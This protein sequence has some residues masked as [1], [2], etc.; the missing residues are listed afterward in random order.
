MTRRVGA[1]F[2]LSGVTALVGEVVWA[3][4]LGL[5]LGNSVWAASAVVTAWMGGMAL[6]AWLGGRVASRVRAHLRWYGLAEAGIGAFFALSEPLQRLLLGLGAR[7]LGEDLGVDPA[8]GIAVRLALAVAVLAV[9]TVL[10][11]LTLPLLVERLHGLGLT[12]RVGHLYGLNTLGGAAGVFLAAYLLL[13]WLGERGSLA[14][15]ALTCAAVA[16]SAVALEGWVPRGVP[17]TPAFSSARLRGYL[18]LVA[19]MGAGALA[20]ELLWVRVLVLHLGSSVYAF[21]AVLAVYLVGLALGS[22]AV[23]RLGSRLGSPG[24]A[25][26]V[27]QLGIAGL[28]VI[29]LPL[30]GGFG[31]ALA[32]PAT[33]IRIP[34]GFASVQAL[35]VAVVSLY[36]LPVAVLFG[37]CFPLAVAADP[38]ARSDGGHAGAIAAANTLGA[39]LGALGAPFLLV[40]ALGVQRSLLVVAAL[41][42]GVGLALRPPAR[43]ARVAAAAVVLAGGGLWV[44]LPRDWVLRQA[45]VVEDASSELLS[46]SESVS[47]TVAVKRY[48]AGPAPWTSLELNGMNVAGTSRSLLAVQQLQGNLPLLQLAQPRRVLHVGFGSGG[49]CWAVSRHPVTAIDVVE[50]APEVLESAARW[51]GDINRGV[52]SDPRVRVVIND[53]RNFLLATDHRYDAILSDSIHPR[54]AGNSTLYTLEYFQLCRSR[55]EPGGVVSMWLPLYSL[56]TESYLRILSAFHRVFPRTAVWYDISTVNENTVVTGSAAPGPL[57]VDWP[58]MAEPAVAASLAAA[59]VGS[60]DDLAA[61]LLLGPAEVARLVAGTPALIDDLPYVEYVSGRVLDRRRTWLANLDLLARAA[62][63]GPS[64]FSGGS[65]DW[66]AAVERRDDALR[67]TLALLARGEPD[68]D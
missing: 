19:A 30:L 41:H 59:G 68:T 6:G 45:S 52:L 61:L 14:A 47:A 43:F 65:V 16:V 53:G 37:A 46:L 49:T 9:P 1:L 60:P 39:I 64:P 18:A 63:R 8:G 27:A 66:A 26:A 10:M 31:D 11:G 35:L 28:V 38:K 32:W 42:L 3:R 15:A 33:V 12:A 21:A 23:R 2:F 67:A 57:R 50:I 17:S 25:L 62:A 5:V 36:L 24:P 40:P 54:H 7:L 34:L 44:G 13:P 22:L 29:Q 20:A 48:L 55:L 51:L 56:D 4:M 58:R